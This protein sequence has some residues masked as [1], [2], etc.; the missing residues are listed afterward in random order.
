MI[1]NLLVIIS[2]LLLSLPVSSEPPCSSL[3]LHDVQF[4]G[5][6]N[7]AWQYLT[8]DPATWKFRI[9]PKN[10]IFTSP[11][12]IQLFAPEYEINEGWTK[13]FSNSKD[14]LITVQPLHVQNFYKR[15]DEFLKKKK[16]SVPRPFIDFIFTF[17]STVE[18]CKLGLAL[19]SIV[20]SFPK[21]KDLDFIKKHKLFVKVRLPPG[22]DRIPMTMNEK[23]EFVATVP[24]GEYGIE[25]EYNSPELS[26][27]FGDFDSIYGL[28]A[29]MNCK[30]SVEQREK[31]KWVLVENSCSH[32]K[33]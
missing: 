8:Q 4:L 33:N 31:L 9:K 16:G 6:R 3:N 30:V 24:I 19:N 14:G 17:E 5:P 25:L 29:G 28:K 13:Y 26:G 12:S 10:G 2:L 32:H 27:S 15:L 18:E 20:V 23:D 11:D 7:N 21:K 1:N 22:L